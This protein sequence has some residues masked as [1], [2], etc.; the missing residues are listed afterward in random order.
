[1][2]PKVFTSPE[3]EIVVAI[4]SFTASSGDALAVPVLHTLRSLH[5]TVKLKNHQEH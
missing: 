4:W 5:R 1:V 3:I 2:G